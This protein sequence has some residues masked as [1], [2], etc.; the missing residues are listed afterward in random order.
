MTTISPFAIPLVSSVELLAAKL[1][2]ISACH[3]RAV[4]DGEQQRQKQ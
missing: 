3:A 4:L 1:L 2:W